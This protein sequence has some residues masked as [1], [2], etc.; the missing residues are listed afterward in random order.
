MA[1]LLTSQ[2]DAMVGASLPHGW[3]E[4]EKIRKSKRASVPMENSYKEN[5]KIEMGQ[6]ANRI[7]SYFC[8]GMKVRARGES[9]YISTYGTT[10]VEKRSREGRSRS[11][12]HGIEC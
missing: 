11:P 9:A 6:H 5:K 1:M 2:G 7:R 8:K 3:G 4:T 10:D 12:A